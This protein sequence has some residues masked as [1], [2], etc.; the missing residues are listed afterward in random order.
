LLSID[1]GDHIGNFERCSVIGNVGVN[2][3][4]IFRNLRFFLLHA[5]FLNL[6]NLLFWNLVIRLLALV[7]FLIAL[8]EHFR[9]WTKEWILR[10]ARGGEEVLIIC[11]PD[12]R[13]WLLR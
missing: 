9:T 2:H 7:G 1:W 11:S 6:R 4:W 8:F 12:L 10:L 3:Q 13:S 5:Y